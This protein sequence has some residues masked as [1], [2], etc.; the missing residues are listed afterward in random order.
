MDY[1]ILEIEKGDIAMRKLHEI[2]MDKISVEERESVI[3]NLLL[4]CLQ[5][6][7]AMVKIFEALKNII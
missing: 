6:T 7:L 3:K 5:D 2:I 4:Y 1:S